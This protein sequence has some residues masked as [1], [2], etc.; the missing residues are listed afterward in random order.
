[1]DNWDDPIPPEFQPC[2]TYPDGDA[3]YHAVTGQ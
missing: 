2:L 3:C 1:M